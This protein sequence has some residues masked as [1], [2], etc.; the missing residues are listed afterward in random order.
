MEHLVVRAHMARITPTGAGFTR[1]GNTW[2]AAHRGAAAT[3]AGMIII[4]APRPHPHHELRVHDF[5]PWI[6]TGRD[7][8]Q[9][10]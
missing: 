4:A 1:G 3:G 9:S 6:P 8:N 5:G 2:A 7:A 10:N